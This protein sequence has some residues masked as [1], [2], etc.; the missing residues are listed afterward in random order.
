MPKA[1]RKSIIAIS[2]VLV[3]LAMHIGVDAQKKSSKRKKKVARSVPVVVVPPTFSPVFSDESIANTAAAATR[4]A[5]SSAPEEG[6]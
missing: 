3:L 1:V 5:R 6:A 2:V 4:T